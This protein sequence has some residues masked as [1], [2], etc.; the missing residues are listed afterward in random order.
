M[1][2]SNVQYAFRSARDSMLR[3]VTIVGA[4]P[5]FIKAGAF[6]RAVA[7]HNAAGEMQ[8]KEILVHTGQHYDHS[9]SKVFFDELG[10]LEPEYNL[11]IGSAHHGRQTGRMLERIEEVLLLEKP[12]AVLVYGDTNSTLAGA[13]AAAKLHIPVAHMEAG[14]RSFNK[15]MPEEV[16]RILTDHVSHFLFCPT[17]NAVKNL[18][19]EGIVDRVY[20]VGDLM[21]DSIL[22]YKRKAGVTTS[23][24][25]RFSLTP[26][27]FVLATVHRPENVDNEVNLREIFTSLAEISEDFSVVVALHPRTK[28]K[29]KQ[30]SV[31][32]PISVRLLDPVSYTQMIEL[33]SNA[34]AILT[35]SGGV[36]K[37]AFF[38]RRP[39]LTLRDETEWVETVACGANTLCGAESSRILDAFRRLSVSPEAAT[40]DS[41]PYGDGQSAQRI[42][43]LLWP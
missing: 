18:T 14:L 20:N 38:V 22:Y 17:N 1:L 3:I 21:F 9:M 16:N 8:I 41:M 19:Q 29:M 6:S 28:E 2:R 26:E 15:K 33:E 35:D 23:C 39:C 42:V 13:L 7:E 36:Q 30:F 31:P 43:N 25:E 27:T 37:E 4:R 12:D 5:Q 40:F 11:G 10:L 34:Y 32:V 24:I